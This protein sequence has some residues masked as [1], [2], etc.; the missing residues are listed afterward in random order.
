MD[1]ACI[2]EWTAG[3]WNGCKKVEVRREVLWKEKGNEGIEEGELERMEE[4]R[5]K[6]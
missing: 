2:K 4:G 6:V 5:F 1:R 3:E